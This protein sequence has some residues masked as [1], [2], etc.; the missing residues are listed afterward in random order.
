MW[1]PEGSRDSARDLKFAKLTT[2]MAARDLLRKTLFPP[3]LVSW[4]RYHLFIPSKASIRQAISK[5][6]NHSFKPLCWN[7]IVILISRSITP[8]IKLKKQ[9]GKVVFRFFR[10]FYWPSLSFRYLWYSSCI[11][12]AANDNR[13]IEMIIRGY[14]H[15]LFAWNC[16]LYWS[17]DGLHAC[18]RGDLAKSRFEFARRMRVKNSLSAKV[19]SQKRIGDPTFLMQKIMLFNSKCGVC[20]LNLHVQNCKINFVEWNSSNFEISIFFF[21]LSK[22]YSTYLFF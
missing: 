16:G 1:S 20:V 15:L 4:L 8:P 9:Q 5:E 19:I 14:S 18:A 2:N 22:I 11:S 3:S 13:E 17:A 12:Y 7:V 21:N 10:S 6:K